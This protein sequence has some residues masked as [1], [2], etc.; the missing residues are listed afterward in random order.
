MDAIRANTTGNYTFVWE[1]YDKTDRMWGKYQRVIH[2]DSLA[3]AVAVHEEFHG[4]LA[5]D[6]A[7][8]YNVIL[9]ISYRAIGPGEEPAT[10]DEIRIS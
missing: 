7:G 4:P 6:D 1:C 2:A 5:P 10:A 9:G 3:N 8:F